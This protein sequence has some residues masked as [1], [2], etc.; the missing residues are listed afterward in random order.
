MCRNTVRNAVTRHINVFV[1]RRYY[2][3]T[4]VHGSPVSPASGPLRTGLALFG[5]S[6]FDGAQKRGQVQLLPSKL[7]SCRGDV[8]TPKGKG[9]N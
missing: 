4:D 7:A 3:G 6:T 8:A 9:A 5:S 2:P 1:H